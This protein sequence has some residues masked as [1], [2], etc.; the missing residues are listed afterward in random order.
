MTSPTII[1]VDPAGAEHALQVPAGWTLMEAA[2]QNG[3]PGIIAEC[4]GCCACATCHVIVAPEWSDR[5]PAPASMEQELLTCT[6]MPATPQS[7][8]GCQV[9]V[10]PD[11][12]GMVV[13]VASVQL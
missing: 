3:V 1:F 4:G 11:L 10:T 7:R 13:S 5:L 9:R 6:A 8:L 2:V 12:D